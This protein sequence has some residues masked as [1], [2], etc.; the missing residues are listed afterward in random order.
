MKVKN[1]KM[2]FHITNNRFIRITAFKG[3]KQIQSFKDI[4]Y[5]S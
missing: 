4:V 3:L 1:A 2:E 5:L